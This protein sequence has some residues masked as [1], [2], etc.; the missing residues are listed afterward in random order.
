MD[1]LQRGA[2]SGAAAPAHLTLMLFS[3]S[4]QLTWCGH[5][6]R[7]YN[8]VFLVCRRHGLL[9]GTST[10][11]RDGLT[12]SA[13]PAQGN[14][15]GVKTML[16]GGRRVLVHAINSDQRR[17]DVQPGLDVRVAMPLQ[18]LCVTCELV[19]G[20]QTEHGARSALHFA[21]ALGNVKIIQMLCQAG[22]DVDLGDKDGATQL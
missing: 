12:T 13:L 10:R 9:D 4:A 6:R 16:Q 17:C 22:A 7:T 1:R 20:A 15:D 2:R 18:D 19:R 14:E 11:N 8:S 3:P 5:L 21:A